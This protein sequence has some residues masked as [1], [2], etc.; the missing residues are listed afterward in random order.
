MEEKKKN[1]N[2]RKKDNQ[3]DYKKVFGIDSYDKSQKNK[4]R[5]S[6][7]IIKPFAEEKNINLNINKATGKINFI[8]KINNEKLENGMYQ[9]ELNQIEN[10]KKASK[11]ELS[12]KLN[13]NYQINFILKMIKNEMTSQDNKPRNS[14]RDRI[15]FFSEKGKIEEK[16]KNSNIPKKNYQN[17]YQKVFGIDSYDKNQKNKIRNSCII[18]KPFAEEKII[19]INKEKQNIKDREL[20]QKKLE[21]KNTENIEEKLNKT[22]NEDEI[23][24]NNNMTEDLRSYSFQTPIKQNKDDNEIIRTQS[25]FHPFGGRLTNF[26]KEKINNMNN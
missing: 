3:N 6:C 1:S 17:D 10:F 11:G 8:I 22:V 14:I 23:K 5:K 7:N 4:I 9:I 20:L 16:K 25:I 2:I 12:I 15:N 24:L 26:I 18:S 21:K 13:N 19:N